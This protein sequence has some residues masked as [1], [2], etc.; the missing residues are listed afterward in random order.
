MDLSF[1]ICS[2]Q[3]EKSIL[4]IH[5]SIFT[6]EKKYI[7]VR[8]KEVELCTSY[9]AAVCGRDVRGTHLTLN[10]YISSSCSQPLLPQTPQGVLW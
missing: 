4:K 9:Q 8:K 1:S 3:G 6:T 10:Y 7:V 2:C 5:I